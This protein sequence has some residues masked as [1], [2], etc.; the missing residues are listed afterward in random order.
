[1]DY[2]WKRFLYPRLSTIKFFDDNGFLDDPDT[3]WGRAVNPDLVSSEN[4]AE[5]PCL[6]ILGEAGIGK[7]HVMNELKKIHETDHEISDFDL[8]ACGSEYS[9]LNGPLDS[10]IFQKWE[11]KQYCLSLFWDSFDECKLRIDT[12]VSTIKNELKKYKPEIIRERLRLRIASRAGDWSNI[13][14]MYLRELWGEDQFAVY[15]LAPLRRQDVIEALKSRQVDDEAFLKEVERKNAT[16][17]SIKPITLNFL[18]NSYK[19]NGKLPETQTELYYEGCKSLCQETNEQRRESRETKLRGKL[20]AEK[21]LIVASRIAAVSIFSNKFAVWTDINQGNVAPEDIPI[22]K[23]CDGVESVGDDEF[24]ITQD[25]IKETLTISGLFTPLGQKRLGWGHQTYAEF[26]AAWY[27]QQHH[28]SLTQIKS[29][30]VHSTGKLIPQLYE[31]S[32]WIASMNHDVFR[33]IMKTDASVLLYSDL[34]T[35]DEEFREAFV[36]NLLKLYD[37]EKLVDYDWK[38]NPRTVYNSYKK[39]K[40][41][42][43]S[44]QLRPYIIDKTK[45][46]IVRRASIKMADACQLHGLQKDLINIV[47]DLSQPMPIR[48]NAAYSIIRI[49]DDATKKKLKPF[50]FGQGGD[51]PDDELKGCALQ[52]LWPENLSAKELFEILTSPKNKSFSGAY[53]M[54]LA[55]DSII[56]YLKPKEL[57]IALNW[58]KKHDSLFTMPYSLTKIL[59]NIISMAIT[60]I[61]ELD[62]L[63]AFTQVI[64]FRLKIY[65]ISPIN[66]EK[67]RE[68]FD[69]VLSTSSNK[70]HLVFEGIVSNLS[71]SQEK[72]ELF[73]ILT[74]DMSS[75]FLKEDFNW[76]LEK[77]KS[78]DSERAQDTWVTFIKQVFF[79]DNMEQRETIVKMCQKFPALTDKFSWYFNQLKPV[80]LDSPE[81]KKTKEDYLKM[82]QFQEMRARHKQKKLR[83]FEQIPSLVEQ[84]EHGDL[85]TWFQLKQSMAHNPELSSGYEFDITAL[86]GWNAIDEDIR[87]RIFDVA[88]TYI[89]EQ[90]PPDL[91]SR[92]NE[93]TYYAHTFAGYSALYLILLKAPE[94]AETIPDHIWQRWAPMVVAYPMTDVD[95]QKNRDDHR[96]MIGIV[97]KKAPGEVIKTLLS[98]IDTKNRKFN[99]PFILRKLTYCWDERLIRELLIKAHDKNLHPKS[100]KA[101]LSELLE[102]NSTEAQS[103]AESLLQSS[104]SN[105]QEQE[106][107]VAITCALLH[108]APNA[109]WSVVWP[110]I[111]NNPEFSDEIIKIIAEELDD[112]QV[113][114][115]NRLSDAQLADFYVWLVRK[116]PYREDPQY[117]GVHKIEL[118]DLIA[119]W[120]DSLLG[121][122][123]SRGTSEAC[124]AVAGIMKELPELDW[125]KWTLLEA[126][127]TVRRHTWEPPRPEYILT[128]ARDQQKYLIQSEDD[129]LN[130]IHESLC[131]LERRLQG[132]TP[133]VIDLWNV[134]NPSHLGK[135]LGISKKNGSNWRTMYAPKDENS[136]SDY[137]KRHLEQDIKARGIIVN[138][139]V[140]IRRGYGAKGENPDIKVEAIPYNSAGNVRNS[141]T[142]TIEAKGC[143]HKELKKAMKTQLVDRYMKDNHCQH[144]LYLVGW[145]NCKQWDDADYRKEDARKFNDIQEVRTFFDDQAT[146]LSTGGLQIRAFVM[147][148][149]LR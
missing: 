31:V 64:L 134:I 103:F 124:E 58:V 147:N 127:N 66:D 39:L 113:R 107:A 1:M 60:Y 148:T 137:V 8:G 81:A 7:T 99:N 123:Q 116:Y 106:R 51:D 15:K 140:E 23:L 143:W 57:P 129:L 22:Q 132:E 44:V 27:I 119:R 101:L 2:N 144:G 110:L 38:Q 109:D 97:Y 96:M 19:R 32:A 26:L 43:L 5:I 6:I 149:A 108:H 138:R 74:Y 55:S 135:S 91:S 93:G 14:E 70:R 49:G 98:L 61:E 9:L 115:L 117:K 10:Q 59:D 47:L 52:A 121:E 56:K 114:I 80:R 95:S 40:H 37:E 45:G 142:V 112:Q 69:D 128:M 25:T 105:T 87:K 42:R 90:S 104:P 111:Q 3:E 136:F 118:R 18:I 71:N 72:L 13:L 100:L 139:E 133:A 145:F 131:R 24:N 94:F 16:P 76:F 28:F 122:L 125:L 73:G 65:G 92:I 35:L 77:L 20:S 11:D 82:L 83:T 33:E 146:S 17:L 120:R 84:C 48:V 30:I 50:A 62:I 36:E 34:A 41:S 75:I 4:I 85:D 68:H 53:S 86:P 130:V 79:W 126:Q 88:K 141:V 89:M 46:I 102:R 12:L 54:F 78:T 67:F 63:Q 29:L 21:R